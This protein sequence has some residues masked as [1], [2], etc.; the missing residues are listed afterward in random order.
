MRH[1]AV[2]KAPRYGVQRALWDVWLGA[3][4]LPAELRRELVD[5]I[6]VLR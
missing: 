3:H 5:K 6:D 4:P 2:R 1:R